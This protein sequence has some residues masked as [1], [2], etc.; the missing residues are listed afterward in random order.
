MKSLIIFGRALALLG[1][2]G[3]EEFVE[4]VSLSPGLGPG[5]SGVGQ[6]AA[7]AQVFFLIFGSF[8]HP[9]TSSDGVDSTPATTTTTQTISVRRARHHTGLLTQ[10]SF[11]GHA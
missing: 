3:P 4:K 7:G 10:N 11:R 9:V 8:H 2:L 6:P 5:E 1:E